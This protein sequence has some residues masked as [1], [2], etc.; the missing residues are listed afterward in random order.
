[1]KK[2]ETFLSNS[3]NH[4]VIQKYRA[5]NFYEIKKT[6]LKI[7]D[8]KIFKYRTTIIFPEFIGVAGYVDGINNDK[9]EIKACQILQKRINKMLKDNE[10]LP[11]PM[12]HEQL[13][14]FLDFFS[15][16]LNLSERR[17]KRNVSFYELIHCNETESVIVKPCSVRQSW[18][19]ILLNFFSKN[20]KQF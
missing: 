9:I 18:G 4:K 3:K 13:C 20:K 8:E 17:E 5:I 19:A 7:G 16:D 6:N 10:D 2:L 12:S 15:K 1:M 14:E 11:A